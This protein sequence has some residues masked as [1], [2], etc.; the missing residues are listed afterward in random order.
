MQLLDGIKHT[1][2][3]DDTYNASPVAVT[4]ALDVLY[5]SRTKQRIAVLGSMNELGEYAR[6]AHE[7]VGRYCDPRKLDLVVTLGRDAER[8]IAPTARKKGCVV[9]SF[10]SYTAAAAF[11]RKMYRRAQSYLRKARKTVCLPKKL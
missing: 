8:W 2:L 3:I 9:H 6:E 7:E 4:A 1:K 10:S 11:V 5:S